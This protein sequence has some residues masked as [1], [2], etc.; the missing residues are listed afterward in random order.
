V[1][2][3]STYESEFR[4]RYVIY[5][6]FNNSNIMRTIQLASLLAMALVVSLVSCKKDEKTK[7]EILTSKSWT[8]KSLTVNPPI[9]NPLTMTSITDV[10]AQMDACEKDDLTTFKANNT[11][12]ED[13]GATKCVATNPQTRTVNWSFNSTESII[14]FDAEDWTVIELSENKLVVTYTN[15]FASTNYTYTATFQ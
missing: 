2:L 13:E 11:A 14:T 5:Q 15:T 6:I 7:T 3:K 10:Y 9:N 12:I 8:L 1:D 4:F